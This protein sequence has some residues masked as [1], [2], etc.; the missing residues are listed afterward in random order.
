MK[1]TKMIE[2]TLASGKG[3]E[4]QVEISW[5]TDHHHGAD[6]DGNRG[7][8]ATFIDDIHFTV[9]E[10]DI[11]GDALSVVEKAEAENLLTQ[12]AENVDIS[13][14]EDEF[15]DDYGW[16]EEMEDDDERHGRDNEF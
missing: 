15:S 12:A 1:A 14:F 9:P 2:V 5:F 10:V 11:D 4:A 3:V 16:R 7:M 8:S 13:E 6:A